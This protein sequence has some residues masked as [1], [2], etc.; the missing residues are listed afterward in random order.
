MNKSLI[1]QV[2]L[3][4]LHLQF[5]STQFMDIPGL[6]QVLINI[7]LFQVRLDFILVAAVETDRAEVKEVERPQYEKTYTSNPQTKQI[8]PDQDPPSKSSCHPC[9]WALL[10][11]LALALITLALLY[12]LGVIGKG[13]NVD[14]TD[15]TDPIVTATDNSKTSST[16]TTTTSKDTI[17]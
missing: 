5:L 4:L 14:S 2:Q 8:G 11:L 15:S 13:N 6:V 16:T 1:A 10:A 7:R 3:P 9:I 17:K 12:G